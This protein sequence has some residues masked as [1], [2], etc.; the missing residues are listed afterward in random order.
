MTT[1]DNGVFRRK[2]GYTVT[3]NDLVRDK[4]VSL[5][6]KGL[7]LLIQSYITMPN[8]IL[9]KTSLQDLCA[10]GKKA[11][12]S[13]W[14]EL[15]SRGYLKV[16]MYPCKGKWSV[17]YEL[18]DEQ[19][20]GAHT[21]YYSGDG[22]VSS[23][24][25]TRS[26]KQTDTVAEKQ[27]TP[28]KRI[29][30]NGIYANGAYANG[31][32]ADGIHANGGNNNNPRK[33]KPKKNN[34]AIINHQSINPDDET[35]AIDEYTEYER[36]IKRNIEYDRLVEAHGTETMDEIVGVML[37]SIYGKRK[38]IRISGTDF[39]ADVVRN[40]LLSLNPAHIEYVLECL[41]SNTTRI[42]NIKAYMLTSLFNAPDTLNTHYN[43]LVNHD[44]YR[45]TDCWGF[46][47]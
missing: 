21:F 15:K 7:Y 29:Y 30:A 46:T 16:H 8:I 4:C 1:N 19:Q 27:R 45:G 20:D 18:L 35:D 31:N 6:A 28:Q 22:S 14:D 32:N 12:E 3:G 26:G 38:S 44:L 9:K 34:P 43:A 40:R 41:S 33:N 36:I 5:K 23:T 17:E 24:N 13:A 10:E 25:L 39:P 47:R 42:N 2:K 37:S 11:F